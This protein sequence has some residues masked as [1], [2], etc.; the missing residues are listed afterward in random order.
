VQNVFSDDVKN[1]DKM[2]AKL[3]PEILDAT[4]YVVRMSVDLD[5]SAG[6]NYATTGGRRVL[7]EIEP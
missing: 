1:S 7:E 3:R 6:C 5:H 4:N 2:W